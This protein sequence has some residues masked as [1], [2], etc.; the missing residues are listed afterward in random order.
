MT[1]G[2]SFQQGGP[3]CAHSGPKGWGRDKGPL[4]GLFL[5]GYHLKG[6][7]PFF[8]AASSLVGDP[9]GPS[10]EVGGVVEWWVSPKRLSSGGR[11][12]GYGWPPIVSVAFTG[13]MPSFFSGWNLSFHSMRFRQRCPEPSCALDW[14]SQ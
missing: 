12:G 14:D 3:G 5:L 1:P 13:D 11:V 10:G 2:R 6:S 7:Q 8:L 9:R 4:E